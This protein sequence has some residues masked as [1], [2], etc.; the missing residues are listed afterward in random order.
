MA[1]SYNSSRVANSEALK[2]INK[3]K[4]VNSKLIE[5]TQFLM[6]QV[7]DAKKA[8]EDTCKQK[9]ADYEEYLIRDKA[10]REA[11]AKKTGYLAENEAEA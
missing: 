11:R 7:N 5:E 9:I 8:I 3:A 6:Q 1:R 4:E 10:E 2:K